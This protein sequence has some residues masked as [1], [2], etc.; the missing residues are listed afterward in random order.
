MVETETNDEQ[1]LTKQGG[2]ETSA[3]ASRGGRNGTS[4]EMSCLLVG[5]AGK[6]PTPRDAPRSLSRHVPSYHM[7]V[8]FKVR[9]HYVENSQNIQKKLKTRMWQ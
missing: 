9:Q 7:V 4:P 8:P 5:I 2:T 1:I 3:N 6:R